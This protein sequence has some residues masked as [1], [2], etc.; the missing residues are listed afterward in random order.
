RAAECR[1]LSERAAKACHR[2][3]WLKIAGEWE[4]LAEIAKRY[5]P[6]RDTAPRTGPLSR[7]SEFRHELIVRSW[8]G[9]SYSR[10]H[11]MATEAEIEAAVNAMRNVRTSGGEVHDDV[12]RAFARAALKAAEI[13]QI[14]EFQNLRKR[15]ELLVDE[16]AQAAGRART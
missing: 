9:R 8:V 15:A 5:G 10:G 4:H 12:L 3:N 11:A 6:F 13:A 14:A 2:E 1:E 16:A 7:G